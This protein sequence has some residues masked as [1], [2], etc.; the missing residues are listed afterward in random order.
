MSR[1]AD[2]ISMLSPV[3]ITAMWPFPCSAKCRAFERSWEM[4]RNDISNS[5]WNSSMRSMISMR[6]EMSTALM[7]SST[8][9]T[10][11]VLPAARASAMR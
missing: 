7:T 9:I 8:R 4:N 5:I 6:S 1:S 3:Y 2:A 11:G 10:S